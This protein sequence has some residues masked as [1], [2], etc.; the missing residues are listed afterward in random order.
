MSL[1]STRRWWLWWLL[2]P[3]IDRY[4]TP[5]QMCVCCNL[6]TSY[7]S[8]SICTNE[9][10]ISCSSFLC[11]RGPGIQNG[12]IIRSEWGQ[13]K[14]TLNLFGNFVRWWGYFYSDPE[15]VEFMIIWSSNE[16]YVVDALAIRG[17]EGRCR[18][19]KASGS[20][21]TCFDPEVSEWGNPP[22]L[23]GITYWIHR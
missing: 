14:I 11:N 5:S 3:S 7:T 23:L 12:T 17:D 8:A 15:Q 9:V 13:S 20:S 6:K 4:E 1:I 21:Q 22:N 10:V 2:V 19:R 18:L 16:A